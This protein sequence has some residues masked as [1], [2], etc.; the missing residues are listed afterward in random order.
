VAAGRVFVSDDGVGVIV[1]GDPARLHGR[2]GDYTVAHHATAKRFDTDTDTWTVTTA[3]GQTPAARVLVDATARDD[4][5]VAAHAIPNCFRI[6]GPHT[7]RQARY[8][9]GCLEAFRRSGSTRIEARARV[10]VHRLLPTRRLSR[11][12]VTGALGPSD[13]VYDGAAVLTYDG[14]DYPARVRL[15]GHFDPIDGH[16]HWQGTAHAELAGDNVTGARVG[17]RTGGHTAAARISERTPWGALAVV[18]AA[19][20]PP[21]PL[22]DVE[23]GH[24]G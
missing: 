15:T 23:I 19:G 13:D 24:A 17:I 10:R 2:L 7:D 16:Y 22:G 20:Y 12:Y 18:G 1:I 3:D 14:Q 9:A 11:F 8:V 21:F 4:D 5:V 6:P